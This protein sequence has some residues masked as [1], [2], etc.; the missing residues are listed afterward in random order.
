MELQPVQDWE[1]FDQ[2][3]EEYWSPPAGIE[4]TNDLLLLPDDDKELIKDILP[5]VKI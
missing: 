2:Q 1:E 4:Y 3:H 5:E